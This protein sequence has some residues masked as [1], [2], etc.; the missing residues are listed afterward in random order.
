[1]FRFFVHAWLVSR[2]Q[3]FTTL[4]TMA[5]QALLSVGFFVQARIVECVTISFSSGSYQ[6]R[7]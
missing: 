6:P 5:H 2:V 7:D 3:L 4:W 1:M